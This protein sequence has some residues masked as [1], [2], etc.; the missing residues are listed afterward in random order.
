MVTKQNAVQVVQRFR[1]RKKRA[2][3]SIFEG[4]NSHVPIF[5]QSVP[6]GDSQDSKEILL[7]LSALYPNLAHSSC[8]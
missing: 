2:K 3:V 4:K 7:F 6:I 1:G 5:R 8:G